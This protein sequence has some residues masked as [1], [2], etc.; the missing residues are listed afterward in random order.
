MR[1]PTYDHGLMIGLRTGR[2]A[3][4][5]PAAV[6]RIIIVYHIDFQ[7]FCRS[8]VHHH[9]LYRSC[10]S[11][12][13]GSRH[14]GDHKSFGV[15]LQYGMGRASVQRPCGSSKLIVCSGSLQQSDTVVYRDSGINIGY[16]VVAGLEK[17]NDYISCGDRTCTWRR[18]RIKEI[19]STSRGKTHVP[20]LVHEKVAAWARYFSPRSVSVVRRSEV[21]KEIQLGHRGV[22]CDGNRLPGSG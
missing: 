12:K 5:L 3:E 14:S 2:C 18:Y 6:G 17:V 8:V 22:V 10:D 1:P 21:I 16:W 11:R 4:A 15:G 13:T 20:V 19:V 9:T 7:T